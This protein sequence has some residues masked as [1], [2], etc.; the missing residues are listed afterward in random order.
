M[1]QTSLKP[2][3]DIDGHGHFERQM[4]E[5][6]RPYCD[7]CEKPVAG[8]LEPKNAKDWLEVHWRKKHDNG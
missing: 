1:S 3:E 6:L 5:Q 8:W 4:L 2:I 7:K